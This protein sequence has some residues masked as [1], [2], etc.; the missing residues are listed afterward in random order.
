MGMQQGG[1]GGYGGM[2]QQ[3]GYGSYV[4]PQRVKRATD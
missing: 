1:M 3:G 4:P 2:Q